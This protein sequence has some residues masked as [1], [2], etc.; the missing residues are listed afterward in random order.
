MKRASRAGFTLVEL[1]IGL[2]LTIILLQ[3]L[4]PL[5]ITSFSSW[6]ISVS[7]MVAHQ[8]ART[9]LE[10]MTRELHFASS[11]VLPL[12]G[13]G[14]AKIRFTRPDYAGKAQTIIFQRGT[15][16]GGNEQTLYRINTSGEPVPLTQNVVSEL[17]FQFQP[18]RLIAVRLTVS[19]WQTKVSDTVRTSVTCVNIPD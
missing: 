11:V 17:S 9:A 6:R 12:P 8:T 13:E 19:D 3:A 5:L 7:R 2:M 15:S 18:P 14:A 1:L 16:S 10:A 4:F